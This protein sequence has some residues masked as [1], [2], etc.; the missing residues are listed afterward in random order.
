MDVILR[1]SCVYTLIIMCVWMT[2]QQLVFAQTRN[3]ALPIVA[4]R[5]CQTF[6]VLFFVTLFTTDLKFN[7]AFSIKSLAEHAP[8]G[9]MY[10]KTQS[11]TSKTGIS[12]GG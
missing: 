12:L 7:T 2:L 9:F 4:K 5:I 1:A 3:I 11:F 8:Y 6:M 10:W